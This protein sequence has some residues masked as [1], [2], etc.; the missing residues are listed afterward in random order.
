MNS[1]RITIEHAF[2]V[3]CNRWKIM[4]HFEKIKMGQEHPHTVEILAV[5]YLLPNISVTLQ[6]SQARGKGT[7]SCTSPS[8][9]EYLELG[10]EGSYFQFNKAMS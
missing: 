7:F 5:S 10:D 8:L 2:S 6:E 3:L 9:E 1:V 4:G